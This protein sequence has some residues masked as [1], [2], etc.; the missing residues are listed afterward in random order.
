MC[1]ASAE[2]PQPLSDMASPDHAR[3]GQANPAYG[4][5][6]TTEMM[7]NDVAL[8]LLMWERVLLMR[9]LRNASRRHSATSSI[10]KRLAA[11]TLQ[12]LR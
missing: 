4:S 11:V 1:A 5:A 8:R 10:R 9:D 7:P 3:T 6:M 2:L 12:C